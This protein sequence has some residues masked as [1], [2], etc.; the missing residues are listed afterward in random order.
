MEEERK[1]RV[2]RGR[3]G[4]RRGKREKEGRIVLAR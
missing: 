4:N 3:D 2:D 1:G